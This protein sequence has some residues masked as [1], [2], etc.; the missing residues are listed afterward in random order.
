MDFM[1]KIREYYEQSYANEL[2]NLEEMNKF[3]ET[4]NLPGLNHV[5]IENLHRPIT[6]KKTET[7]V[8]NYL[9]KTTK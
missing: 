9:T 2:D 1:E 6:R 8:K 3:L 7:V 5:E 4:Q